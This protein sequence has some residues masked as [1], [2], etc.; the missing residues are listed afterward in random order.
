M[1]T[2]EYI[3]LAIKAHFN[4]SP[5]IVGEDH[6]IIFKKALGKCVFEVYT[7]S[8]FAALCISISKVYKKVVGKLTTKVNTTFFQILTF[9]PCSNEADD[10]C[11]LWH[12]PTQMKSVIWHS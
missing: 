8:V 2:K 9:P 4:S 10:A 7:I 1:P 11:I 12:F 3:K 5:E 6:A